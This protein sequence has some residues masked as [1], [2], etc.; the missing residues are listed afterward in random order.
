MAAAAAS[1]SS[2][3]SQEP[4]LVPVTGGRMRRNRPHSGVPIKD[5]RRPRARGGGTTPP[6]GWAENQR[7]LLVHQRR[8]LSHELLHRVQDSYTTLDVRGRYISLLTAYQEYCQAMLDIDGVN[9]AH[10]GNVIGGV[11]GPPL[12]EHS[13]WF[14]AGTGDCCAPK[15]IHACLERGLRPHSMVEWWHGSPPNTATKQGRDPSGSG[16][17]RI[18]GYAF[19]SCLKCESVLGSL[20]CPQ[21]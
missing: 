8:A 10:A 14:P 21:L 7:T 4:P 15:L 1:S 9:Q 13:M 19:P 12:L 18:H 11:R 6:A 3:S 5:A 16:S 17:A 20:L 2:S